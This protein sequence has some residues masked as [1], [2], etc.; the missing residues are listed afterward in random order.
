MVAFG[1]SD[2]A[3]A[4][5]ECVACLALGP[6]DQVFLLSVAETDPVSARAFRVARTD[7]VVL[8]RRGQSGLRGRLAGSVSRHVAGGAACSILVV[9]A[10]SRAPGDTD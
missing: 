3:L 8:G 9:P 1:G 10:V 2:E 6:T 5:L 4:G 7:F